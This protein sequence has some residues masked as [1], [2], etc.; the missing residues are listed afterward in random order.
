[1]I[2]TRQGGECSRTKNNGF[3]WKS[4]SVP[5]P[6]RAIEPRD[7]GITVSGWGTALNESFG[8]N[9]RSDGSWNII[10]RV[11]R[12]RGRLF[13]ERLTSSLSQ[14]LFWPSPVEY[15]LRECPVPDG[16]ERSRKC[17][18][19][20]PHCGP[21]RFGRFCRSTYGTGDDAVTSDGSKYF[22]E[23]IETRTRAIIRF[24]ILVL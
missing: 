21:N 7:T 3:W 23:T 18:T 24:N 1:M 16:I 5:S 15:C 2:V 14:S 13:K 22:P 11:G 9:N 12:R 17:V 10:L 20:S 8:D 4:S 19:Y 6:L